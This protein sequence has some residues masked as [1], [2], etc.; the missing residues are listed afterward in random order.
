MALTKVSYSMI[1]G[2]YIN[3]RDF[4]AVGDGVADDSAAIQAAIDEAEAQQIS[5]NYPGSGAAVNGGPTVYF[6]IGVYRVNS[7]LTTGSMRTVVLIGDGKVVIVGNTSTTKTVDFLTGT[8][9]RYFTVQNIQFQNFDTVFTISTNN[10]DLSRWDIENCQ[11]A[12]INLFIDTVSHPTS[13]STV[14]SFRDCVWQYDCVQIARIFCD[15][16]TFE[17][18]W[19]GSGDDTTSSI[20][21]NSNLSFY[22]CMF[23]PAGSGTSGRCAVRLTNDNGAGGTATDNMRG[24]TFDGCRM[25]NEGGNG[26]IVVCDFP[27]ANPVTQFTPRIVF[28]SC[29]LV[30]Y[31][32]APYEVG[33]S[34]SGIVY[35]IQYPAFVSFTDCSFLNVGGT[36]SKV[37]AKS[38]ALTA[39][40]H[41]GFGIEMDESSYRAATWTV[42]ESSGYTLA[43]S[44]RQYINNPDPYVFRDINEDAWLAVVDTATAGQKKATFTLT[45]GQNDVN[46][47]T[48]IAFF[49]YLGD[50]GSLTNTNFSY[51]CASVYIVTIQGWFSGSLQYTISYTKL[52]GS[53]SGISG[54]V[55]AD[56]VSM[57]FGTGDTGSASTAT[58]NSMQVTVAFGT[59][60]GIGKA[61]I[62]PAFQKVSRYGS[63]P[64]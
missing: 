28:Q 41:D 8:T 45:P 40:A 5:N 4:G 56:I 36:N 20:Y 11:A 18:C 35:L 13:R 43:A 60:M 7:G 16:V 51:Q 46:Y 38:D 22:S 12:G 53:V 48:P 10:L 17:S 14:V 64:N 21:A 30:A 63:Q 15:S 61:K 32:G 57:H 52:H 42:G 49:L 59:N 50:Q 26:P 58:A 23:V 25:S 2:A 47:A 33:N 44:M 19:I 24:V 27:V 3:V 29:A 9:V 6:P 54:A 62:E 31:T 39:T 1:D 37:V 55:N 34:E